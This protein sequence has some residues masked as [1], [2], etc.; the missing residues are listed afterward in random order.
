M[1]YKLYHFGEFSCELNALI[2]A[3]K[4]DIAHYKDEQKFH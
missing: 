4:S 1:K 2:F 3:F